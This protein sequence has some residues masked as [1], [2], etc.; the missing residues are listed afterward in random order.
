MIINGDAKALEW[1]FG[2]WMAKDE[3]AIQEIIDGLDAHSD[4]QKKFNLPSRFIAKIFIF[5]LIYGGTEYSYAQDPD[6]TDVSK[7]PKFWRRVIEEFY[8]K[9]PGWKK[10]HTNL[11]ITAT[12]TGLITIPTGRTWQFGPVLSKTGEMEW[13]RTTILNYPIQGGSA[14][15]MSLARVEY[16]KE[17]RKAGIPG[18][19]LATVH[20]S[21]VYDVPEKNLRQAC[22]L[23]NKVFSN[24]PQYAKQRFGFDYNLPF[25][26]EIGIGP[27]L[28]DLTEESKYEFRY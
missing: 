4:N 23:M 1:C 27:N 19:P 2:S 11:M 14:D 28:N 7:D 13:P 26:V 8:R 20:D 12:R 21:L 24:V 17:F 9:Y 16:W 25:R 10:F 15:M 3:V 22:N 6:F 18:K 5:R